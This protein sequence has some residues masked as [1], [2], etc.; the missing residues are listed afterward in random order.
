MNLIIH[1]YLVTRF[2]R[3]EL[4][5]YIPYTHFIARG[6]GAAVTTHNRGVPT[7][8]ELCRYSFLKK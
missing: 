3:S 1:L 5:L 4:H 6:V 8:Q 7:H 2:N